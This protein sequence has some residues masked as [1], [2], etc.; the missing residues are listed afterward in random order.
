MSK[1]LLLNKVWKY[2]EEIDTHTLETHLYSLRKK[3]EEK[4]GTKNLIIHEEKKGY[5]INKELL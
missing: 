3:I 1:K 2:S 4:L 5:F